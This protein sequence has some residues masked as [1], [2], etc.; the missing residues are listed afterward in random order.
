MTRPS[1]LFIGP[2]KT[3]SSWMYHI[4]SQH[5]ECFIPPAKDTYF[6]D[7]YYDRGI[8]WYL[9]HFDPAPQTAKAVGELSHDYLFSPEAAARIHE[10]L[11][12]VTVIA[13]LRNPIARSL[14]QYQ[15]MRRGGEVGD[16]FFEAV[17]K[18]PKII[19]N[20]RYLENVKTY[21]DT[22]GAAQ[23]KVLIF[24]DLRE[25]ASAFGRALLGHLGLNTC[26]DLPFD[27]RVREAGMARNPLLSRTL[28]AGANV[29][30][31]LGLPNLVGRIKNS[32]AAKLAYRD[33]KPGERV[34]LTDEQQAGLWAQHFG[35]ENEALSA[36]IGRDLS[37]WNP[38][39]RNS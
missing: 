27:D 22:F 15:Y 35:P 34:T 11:P 2:D 36:L 5:P 29:A 18:F 14:S 9:A 39:R 30:R 7:R 17:T 12:D 16:D 28:K 31:Q 13:C 19:E 4:L 23:V 24:E 32:S 25:D 20:S 1:F 37:Y 6:F 33:I 21:I 10:H 8:Q 26:V 3:G 38:E